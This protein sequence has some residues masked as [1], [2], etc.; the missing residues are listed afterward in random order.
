MSG[1]TASISF[2]NVLKR[3]DLKVIKTS[4]DNMNEGVKFHLYGKSTSGQSVDLYAT[5]DKSGVA[6]FKNVLVGT[7]YTLEEVETAERYII[8]DSQVA[9]IEWEKVT[10]NDFYNELKRGD[11]KVVKTSEDNMVEGVKF[12]LYGTSLSGHTVDE[13]PLSV[14]TYEKEKAYPHGIYSQPL[15]E[16][17]CRVLQRTGEHS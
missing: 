10:E 16:V 15:S 8:P 7:N 3:S 14:P 11:L 6:M 9:V 1:Q 4:E 2:K 5:T 17:P 12:H 13:Y